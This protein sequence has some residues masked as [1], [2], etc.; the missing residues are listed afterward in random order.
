V[1]VDERM[2]RKPID[3]ST[4]LRT[5]SYAIL[6]LG[7]LTA[8]VIYRSAS[9][10]PADPLG[11]DPENSKQFLRQME[12]YG[13]KANV[14]AYDLRQWF[15]GLWHGRSLAFTVAFIALLLAAGFRL[16]AI[17][18]PPLADTGQDSDQGDEEGRADT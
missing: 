17:P 18:L 5:I 7:L 3:R 12:L 13:G 16:A 10:A 4:V 6:A 2:L 11:Y 8:A 1:E 15:F 9:Q 14:L